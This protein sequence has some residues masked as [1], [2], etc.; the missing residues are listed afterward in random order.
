MRSWVEDEV[1]ELTDSWVEVKILEPRSRP[2]VASSMCGPICAQIRYKQTWRF[3][4]WLASNWAWM[5]Q[6]WFCPASDIMKLWNMDK[7]L[8]MHAS[9]IPIGVSSFGIVNSKHFSR[10]TAFLGPIFITADL[11][12]IVKICLRPLKDQRTPFKCRPNINMKICLRP[13]DDQ[14]APFKWNHTKR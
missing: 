8:N 7:W 4:N 14:S 3:V 11:T 2:K 1:L 10:V 5:L 13:L 9:K 12:S 6:T